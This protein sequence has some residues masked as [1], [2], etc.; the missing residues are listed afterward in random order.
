MYTIYE[1]LKNI[2]DFYKKRYSNIEILMQRSERS[3][4]NIIFLQ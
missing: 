4:V 3:N 1:V 2:F